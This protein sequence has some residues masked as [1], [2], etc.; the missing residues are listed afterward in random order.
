MSPGHRYEVEVD[1]DSKK[2]NLENMW[3]YYKQLKLKRPMIVSGVSEAV[4]SHTNN[5]S[6]AWFFKK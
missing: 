1:T 6:K 2:Q 4:N 3:T 5:I